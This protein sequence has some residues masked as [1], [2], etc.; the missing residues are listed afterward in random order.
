MEH[1]RHHG[2]HTLTAVAR[3]A[4]GNQTTSSQVIVTVDNTAP[5]VSVTAPTAGASV[6]GTTVPVTATAADNV[7]VAGVQ[8]KLDGADLGLEDTS[9]DGGWGVSWDTIAAGNGTH[10][11]TAV[12]RD[13][14]GNQTT[15]TPVTVTVANIPDVTAPTGVVVSAPSGNLSGT[16]NLSAVA[17]DNVGVAGVQFLVNGNPVGNE[18]PA[19]PY[20]VSWNTTTVANG[21]YAVTARARDAAGN[22]TTSTAVNVTVA[23]TENHAPV[24]NP[25]LFSQDPLTGTV[26]GTVHLSDADGDPLAYTMVGTPMHGALI[27]NIYSGAYTYTPSQAA[28]VAADQTSG[29]DTDAFT[30]VVE[31]WNDHHHR[32]RLATAVP[33]QADPRPVARYRS[34]L[35]R[36]ASLSEEAM[37]SSPTRPPAT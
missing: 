16:V 2:T 25:T 37:P 12:A 24:V 27:F 6:S 13:A 11:L 1:H 4:A 26:T 9:S 23:N 3:D 33:G 29:A 20:G 8:F 32:G 10:T 22:T 31:R 34:V 28:R 19:A 18:D 30:V 35:G 36:P 14:A 17:S 7:G 21:T 5:T 15:S